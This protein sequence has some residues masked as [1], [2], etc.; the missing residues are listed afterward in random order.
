MQQGFIRDTIL[1]V[2]LE[3]KVLY[4][5]DNNYIWIM[6]ISAISLFEN[7][8][9]LAGL[10]VYLLGENISDENKL[11]LRTISKKYNRK[12]NI[13]DVPRFK[14]PKSIVSARWPLSAFT[15]LF[16]AQLLPDGIEKILY[17]D[18]DTII[19]GNI[20]PL[21]NWNM[22][23]KIFCGVKDCVGK[24]YKR[25]I[26]L[27]GND[28]YINAGVLLIDLKKLKNVEMDKSIDKYMAK[29]E[30]FISYADQDILNG[31]FNKET[32][33]LP[34]K[35]DVMTIDVAHTY[36]EIKLLRKPVNFYNRDEIADAVKNPKIIHYTTNMLVVRPWFKNSDHPLK[37][38][39]EKYM[40]ISPWKDHFMGNAEFGK[41]GRVIKAVNILPEGI[42]YRVLG[43]VHAELK[44]RYTRIKTWR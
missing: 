35:Y 39:F 30:K 19:C 22:E 21:E 2:I 23:G 20:S 4:T 26:G 6:G 36:D 43:L 10:E 18:C 13:I 40:K 11:L 5:C 17:L 31:I 14:I 9:N 1:G 3:M 34:P 15:R 32:G 29:Y 25:N 38:E 37:K 7:N 8:K 28:A 24:T 44:P 41:T 12:I 27:D 33:Y 42:A 16:S